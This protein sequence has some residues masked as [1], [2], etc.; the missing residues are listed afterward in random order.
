MVYQLSMQPPT[1]DQLMEKDTC[2]YAPFLQ[3]KKIMEKK[4]IIS[5]EMVRISY[6]ERQTLCC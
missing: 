2:I 6:V 4:T 5:V 1:D 3:R